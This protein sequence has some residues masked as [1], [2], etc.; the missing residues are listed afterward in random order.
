MRIIATSNVDYKHIGEISFDIFI[1]PG[2]GFFTVHLSDL[3]EE[4]ILPVFGPQARSAI[5]CQIQL[6]KIFLE[7]LLVVVPFHNL[8]SVSSQQ[9]K[10]KLHQ[11]MK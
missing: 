3:L 7:T 4:S 9:S 11:K 10:G 8:L 6:P 2:I 5:G 1:I